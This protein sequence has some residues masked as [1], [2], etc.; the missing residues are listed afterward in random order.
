VGTVKVK[1]AG[2]RLET[3]LSTL[4]LVREAIGDLRLRL[5]ANGSLDEKSAVDELER[6]VAVDPELVEEPVEPRA[7]AA[8][9]PSPVRLGLDESLQD[10]Q[11]FERLVPHLERLQCVAVVLKPMALGGFAACHRL[12]ERAE[13]ARLDVTVSHLF[14][15]PVALTA[16][17]HLALAIASRS[18][19]SGLDAHGGLTAW[20]ETRLPMHH[21]TSIVAGYE[22]GLGL[23]PLAGQP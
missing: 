12:A 6:L 22:A 3:Q 19:A 20:P 5:D 4:R 11:A 21:P 15:G 17:A 1:L 18:R 23:A 10:P 8:L 14:D 13:A 16:A 9:G 2:P 7:L